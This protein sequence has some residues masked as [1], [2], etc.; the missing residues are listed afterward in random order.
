MMISGSCRFV[1]WEREK[2]DAIYI[3]AIGQQVDGHDKHIM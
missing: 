1:E 3:K 2:K